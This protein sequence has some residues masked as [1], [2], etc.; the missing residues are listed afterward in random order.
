M[1]LTTDFDSTDGSVISR[2]DIDG[3]VL[4]IACVNSQCPVVISSEFPEWQTHVL[5]LV[6]FFILGGPEHRTWI[7]GG[8]SAGGGAPAGTNRI[9]IFDD[10]FETMVD[11]EVSPHGWLV[12]L[13]ASI[14]SDRLGVRYLRGD[15][16]LLTQ[17]PG[18]LFTPD[19]SS[20]KYPDGSNGWTTYAPLSSGSDLP[21]DEA[22]WPVADLPDHDGGWRTN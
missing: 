22:P 9:Q 6:C 15:E 10:G 13:P 4:L 12:P 16:V 3:H 8:S 2:V 19:D 21:P 5:C 7:L 14:E 18:S 20:G 11:L 17:A 1:P